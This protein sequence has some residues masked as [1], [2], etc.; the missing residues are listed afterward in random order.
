LI[1][2]KRQI[3]VS[4]LL[5]A[6][7]EWIPWGRFVDLR[8]SISFAYTSNILF[9]IGCVGI[10]PLPSLAARLVATVFWLRAT[11]KRRNS[12]LSEAHPYTDSVIKINQ[13]N[14]QQSWQFNLPRKCV[15][16]VDS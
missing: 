7:V 15:Y 8:W 2:T 1:I 5:K 9:K 3:Q 13:Q 16:C 4:S 6:E 10:V 12:W 14:F 11:D